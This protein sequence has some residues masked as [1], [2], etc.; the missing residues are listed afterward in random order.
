MRIEMDESY[1]LSEL[2]IELEQ[3]QSIDLS[4]MTS[5]ERNKH[6]AQVANMAT[7]AYA[8]RATRLSIRKDRV[9]KEAVRRTQR[10]AKEFRERG[11]PC[12]VQSFFML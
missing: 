10:L 1:R 6:V 8:I 9:K 4:R 7:L 5:E 12:P 3:M 2:D 11:D